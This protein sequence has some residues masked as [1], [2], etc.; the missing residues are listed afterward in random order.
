MND[1]V[2]P[3]AQETALARFAIL[4][5][6]VSRKL[7]KAETKV[8]RRAILAQVHLFPDGSYRQISERTLRR[9]LADYRAALPQGTKAALEAL[10]PEKRSDKGIPRTF[11]ASLVDEAVKLKVELPERSV[12]DILAHFDKPPKESAL[13]FHLRRRGA[14]SAR[15]KTTGKAFRRREAKAPNDMW[16]CDVLDGFPL[17]DPTCPDKFKEAHLMAFIDD[18]SRLV[19]HGEWYFRESLP[20]LFDTYKKG[21]LKFGSAARLYWDNGAAFRSRQVRLVAARLGSKV[22]YSTPYAPEG[23]GK[24]ERFF[25]TVTRSFVAEAKHAQIATLEELNNAFWGWLE[26]YH[27]RKHRTTKMTP[28]DRWH[29]GAA[30]IRRPNPAEI[31]E[32]F[33]WEDDRVVTK[34][35]TVSLAG[36]EYR[37]DDAL[38]GQTVQVRYDPLDLATVRVYLG[39]AFRQVAE[40]DKL[41]THTHRKATPHRKEDKYL[42]LPSSRRLRDKLVAEHKAAADAGFA[43]ASGA[44]VDRAADDLDTAGFAAVLGGALAR[45]LT[46]TE[47]E[48]ASQFFRRYAPLGRASVTAVL[49]DLV[50]T[51]G[52]DRHL[53]YYLAELIHALRGPR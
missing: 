11:D 35:A 8:T 34:T 16:Q 25:K 26:R 52:P 51:K 45:P 10:Y 53:D 30:D 39:G 13:A 1:I 27:H 17:P 31:H 33:L 20:C 15:L 19:P 21:T 44:P 37:V 14:T 12:N 47:S 18:H 6:L 46:Q 7:S 22:I 9:W 48:A 50:A 41:V 36:N 3:S 42:P 32:I 4:A 23:R 24:I 38:V 2:V 40:P 5:P 29:A 28:W 43:V 49:G